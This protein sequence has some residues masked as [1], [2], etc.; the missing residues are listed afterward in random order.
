MQ[1]CPKGM[2]KQEH[3]KWTAQLWWC[4]NPEAGKVKLRSGQGK[5][6]RDM[7]SVESKQKENEVKVSHCLR[8]NTPAWATW[9]A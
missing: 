6:N 7:R 8:G 4:G 3:P 1:A 9:P 5:K 2:K